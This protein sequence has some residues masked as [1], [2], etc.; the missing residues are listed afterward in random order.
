MAR[1]LSSA[2]LARLEA[3]S[4]V[5]VGPLAA[6]DVD[7]W[8]AQALVALGEALGAEGGTFHFPGRIPA[9]RAM[10]DA[11]IRLLDAFVSPPWQRTGLSPDPVISGFHDM[12]VARGVEVWNMHSGDHLI[13]G[14]GEA[15]KTAF[16]HEVLRPVG[17]GD[18]HALFVPSPTGSAMLS[19]HGFVRA[20][21]PAE[22]LPA[23]RLLF[24]AFRAGLDALARLGAQRAAL[25]AV[26]EPLASFDADGREAYRNRAL[27]AALAADPERERVEGTLRV[28]AAAHRPLAFGREAGVVPVV[29]EVATAR[30]RYRLRGVLVGPGAFG[31]TDAFLVTVEPPG[32]PAL[33][34]AGDLRARFGLTRREA[35]V[36]LLLAEGLSNEALAERL[37]VS[38]HTARH[39]VEAVLAKLD[40]AGRAAVAARLLQSA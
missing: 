29:R 28:L 37:F 3:A 14:T 23:L 17:A 7:A 35:E 36:A 8:R 12:L 19:V 11:H 4:R 26:A 6:P 15:W 38:R 20:P 9:T 25:D 2:A 34:S 39:H 1:A 24:P 10:D 13:G 18:D 21:E 22:H 27:V 33:P 32:G 16:Y 31:G 40:V 5:L 30:G